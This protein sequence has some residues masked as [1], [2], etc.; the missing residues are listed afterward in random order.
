MQGDAPKPNTTNQG[1]EGRRTGFIRADVAY[2]FSYVKT[3]LLNL[4]Y[5]E[6]A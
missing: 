5:Y 1:G 6:M 3:N 2:Q 4:I